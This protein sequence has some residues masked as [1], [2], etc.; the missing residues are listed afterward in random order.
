MKRHLPIIAAAALLLIPASSHARLGET[1]AQSQARYGA[2]APEL[3]RD[4]E[5]PL[6]AGVKDLAYNF[7][8]WRIR[9]AFLNGAA[10]RIEYAQ[11]PEGGTI[12]QITD[13]Q[14][15]T[16]LDAESNKLKWRDQKPARTGDIGKDIGAAIA[17]AI[18]GKAWERSDH[19]TA[20][21]KTGNIF[22]VLENPAVATYEKKMSKAPGANVPKF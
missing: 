15:K 7:Q 16:I 17:G 4:D 9:C 22:L 18:A 21:L 14:A 1:E 10:V 8:G 6:V 5:K 2:P 11:I 19:A 13:A 12:K 20:A 3:I